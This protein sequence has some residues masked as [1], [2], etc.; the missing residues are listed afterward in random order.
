MLQRLLETKLYVVLY[1]AHDNPAAARV[2]EKVGFVKFDE[3]G[4]DV[5]GA[6]RWL[7]LGFDRRRVDLG[8]W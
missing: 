7:E 6:E 5:P 8:H 2:Y 3:P 4:S 1:V